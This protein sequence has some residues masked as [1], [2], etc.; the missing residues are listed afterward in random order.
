[1]T[2]QLTLDQIVS[3]AKRRGF[4]F[5]SS[6]IYGGL[7]ACWDYGPLG[8]ELKNNIKNRWWEYMVH[9]RENV[10]G[11]DGSIL[12]HPEIWVAS[13]HVAGFHDPMVDCKESKKRYREDHLLVYK[14]PVK[15]DLPYFAFVEAAAE[16]VEKK[17]K[18][19]TKGI[20]IEDFNVVPLSE[21]PIP[22]RDRVI[23]PD[24]T[25]PGTLTEP[26]QFNLMFKTQLGALEGQ[27]NEIYLRPETAQAIFVNFKNI[28]QTSRQRVPFGI[29]QIGKAFRNEIVTKAFIFRSREFEQM[30]MQFFI[31]PDEDDQ[32]YEWWKG[33]RHKFYTDVLGIRKENLNWEPH[34]PN[35]LAHYAKAAVDITFKFPMGWQ[36]IEGI[37]NRG[38]FDLS[39]HAKH[40]GKDMS[41]R[42]PVN[43]QTYV[44]KV[45]ETSAGVDRSVLM[46]LCEAY[47]EVEE[48]GEGHKRETRSVLQFHPNIAPISVAIFPLS[49]KD[50]LVDPS[51]RLEESLRA[52]GFRTS[53]DVTGSIGKRYRRQDEIGTPFCLTFDFDSLEDQAV[54]IRHR[55]T[56]QQD[57]VAIDRVGDTLR[58]KIRNWNTPR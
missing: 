45:I 49:K 4:I 39:Q 5:Q 9:A 30:E 28:Q 56:M 57:R 50:E 20:P 33:E 54:T 58:E 18:K 3:L 24:A 1:M 13:G 43:N 2:E 34:P 53:Y 7:G 27:T 14:H 26:R 44:P 40:S 36:E 17:V 8:V 29:A 16:E 37:H 25:E 10:V 22:E 51:H 47:A 38:D 11:M 42:D 46:A 55:D 23:G 35:K 12:M 31:P 32:W 41:Y 6:E 15:E 21:I 19:M 52:Q 48:E